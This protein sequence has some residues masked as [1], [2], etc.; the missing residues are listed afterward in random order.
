M[1]TYIYL[2]ILHHF[3]MKLFV[4][5]T[6]V[7]FQRQS[8]FPDSCFWYRETIFWK[9]MCLYAL[10][11]RRESQPTMPTAWVITYHV[12]HGYQS[13]WRACRRS[14]T[15]WLFI[16][17]PIQNTLADPLPTDLELNAIDLHFHI[18]SHYHHN[19]A[20]LPSPVLIF[21][22]STFMLSCEFTLWIEDFCFFYRFNTF[23]S[24]LLI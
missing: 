8:H 22:P 11:R 12:N 23:C 7:R 10:L 17:V 2:Y 6:M 15:A 16:S 9:W 24:V 1:Y 18:S 20:W 19:I 14:A 21:L 13:Q 4:G 5:S 3:L